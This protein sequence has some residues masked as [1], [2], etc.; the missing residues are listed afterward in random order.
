MGVG[1]CNT[2]ATTP[3]TTPTTSTTMKL[4]Q[5]K[6]VKTTRRYFWSG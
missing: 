2:N 4:P 6:A 5:F 3:A 1:R